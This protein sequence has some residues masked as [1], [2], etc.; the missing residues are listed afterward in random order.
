MK[1]TKCRIC[2]G[3]HLEKI[4]DLG[5]QTLTGVFPVDG[6]EVETGNLCLVKCTAEGGCGLIQL[7]ESFEA[8]LM[9]G[10]NYGYRSGLNKSMVQHLSGIVDYITEKV[11]L[12]DEEL[13]VDIGSNDGTLLGMYEDK[14]SAKLQK[15]GVDPSGEKFYEYYKPGITLVPDFFDAD[16]VKTITDKKA[17]VVTSIAMFYDLEDPI[18]FA[19]NVNDVLAEDGIWITEQSYCPSML[20]V[21]S[22]DTVCHEHLEYYSLKQIQWIADRAGLKII[23]VELNETNGGSFRVT[24]CKKSAE[25][26]VDSSVKELIEFEISNRI[27]S[28]EYTRDFSERIEQSKNELL[29]FL[30]EK[31]QNGELVLGYGA[32]TKGNVVLQYCGIT[33]ELLPAIMEVN[34]DKYNHLTPG[35]GI[36][37]ISEEEGRKKTP[38]YL[39]VLPWHF[40]N[41]ILEKEEQY[42]KETGC[43]FVFALPKFEVVE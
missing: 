18:S 36:R 17:K 35:T 32:S 12:K 25:Y 40:K 39:L 34:P 15:V 38:K 22:Y 10:E 24:L 42:M 37:I 23:D 5:C 27:D 31:K 20:E 8:K 7:S 3:T 41:N 9:Y 43:K 2:G 11:V 28:L 30:Q 14:S 4:V 16:K 19:K 33:S 26:G 21:C 13:V 1:I 6:Q 29:Q